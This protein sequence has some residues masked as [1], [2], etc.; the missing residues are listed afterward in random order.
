[1]RHSYSLPE[2]A[3]KAVLA[4]PFCLGLATH[5]GAE[6]QFALVLPINCKL[7]VTCFVQNY[8]DHDTSEKISDFRC[9]G[10]AYDGHDGTDFRIPDLEIQR[11]G[12]EVLSAAAGRVARVRDGIEDISV[13]ITGKHAIAGKEC[14]NGAVVEHEQGWTTQYCHL[15]KGSLRVKP[16]DRVAAGQSIGLVGLSGNT[17]FPHLHLTVRHNGDVVDPFAYEASRN[18]CNG[19]RSIWAAALLPKMTYRSREILNFGYAAVPVTMDRIESGDVKIQVVKPGS[20]T[21]VAYIRAIGLQAGD[22][23]TLTVYT[24][25][26]KAFAEYRA[27][28]LERDKAQFFVSAGRKRKDV[29]WPLGTYKATYVIKND[30]V[31]VMQ[32]VFEFQLKDQ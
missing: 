21:L 31:E 22:E 7:G 12:I 4:L 10:R 9:G 18:F 29:P 17:E 30:G 15:A 11:K 3:L 28:A 8:M 23:Q 26:G 1:M 20:D 2:V 19:G 25:D 24:P 14:G 5:V 6:E 32:T 13:R 27:P 16:G